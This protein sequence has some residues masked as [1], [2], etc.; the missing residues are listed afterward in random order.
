MNV[1]TEPLL[2]AVTLGIVLQLIFYLTYLLSVYSV[3]VGSTSAEILAPRFSNLLTL[4]S[5]GLMVGSGVGSGFVYVL[6]HAR[7]GPVAEIAARGG[8]TTGAITFATSVIIAG[9]LAIIIILPVLGNQALATATAAELAAGEVTTRML[10]RGAV[11]I[12]GGTVVLSG[13]TAVLG[14]MLGGLGGGLGGVFIQSR[15][16]G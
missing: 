15:Q 14:A 2:T 11:G 6:L 9:I 4:L 13:I 5:C 1:K 8:A 7:R 16:S 10:S 12:I 3:L